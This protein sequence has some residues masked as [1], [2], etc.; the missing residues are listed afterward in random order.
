MLFKLT[1]AYGTDKGKIYEINEDSVLS[2]VGSTKKRGSYG[3][4]IVADGIGGH[5]AGEVASQLVVD[6]IQQELEPLLKKNKAKPILKNKLYQAV[7]KA[8]KVVYEQANNNPQEVGDMGSTL[9]CALIT[10]NTAIIANVGDSRT[11]RLRGDHLYQITEDHSLVGEMV[12]KG[13]VQ[14]EEVF[15][16][17]H[18]SVITR[19]LGNEPE[20]EID[21]LTENLNAGDRLLLCS[22]G[23]W[24]MTHGDEVI[25]ELL[26]SSSDL[27]TVANN[28]VD[29][30]NE[31]GGQDNISVVVA[32]ITAV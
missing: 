18:R 28:L 27:D 23:L 12:R 26:Q 11:Y 25:T 15:N 30:A 24:E 21:I 8:N 3:L 6:T 10:G 32:D 17:P 7:K 5:K 1:A 29:K 20:V 22:D 9:T 13:L 4:L 14:P 2:L 16:H 31:N 19:A